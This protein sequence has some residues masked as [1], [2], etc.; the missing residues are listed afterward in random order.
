MGIMAIN[1]KESFATIGF[2]PRFF[3]E[4]FYPFPA[5]FAIGPALF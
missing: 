4:I 3:V 2:G 5:N 1:K